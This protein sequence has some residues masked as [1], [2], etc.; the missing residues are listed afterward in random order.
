LPT[1]FFA[2]CGLGSPDE[3][4]VDRLGVLPAQG[5]IDVILPAQFDRGAAMAGQVA[6][7]RARLHLLERRLLEG[8]VRAGVPEQRCLRIQAGGNVRH[9]GPQLLGRVDILHALVVAMQ[10]EHD[11]AAVGEFQQPALQPALGEHR[12]RGAVEPS[13]AGLV[14]N[15]K[16]PVE[17]GPGPGRKPAHVLAIEMLRGADR[18]G[19]RHQRQRAFEP[20]LGLGL[21]QH[22]DQIMHRRHA[23]PLVGMQ[24]RLDID[25]RRRRLGAGQMVHDQL[26][27][28]A[29]GFASDG[30]DLGLHLVTF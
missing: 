18:V 16:I 11:S 2:S 1:K 12:R 15:R 28:H 5:G 14:G 9:F 25:A 7:F 30:L 24:A 10:V 29:R 21:F 23:G 13:H 19:M 26:I 6:I 3:K 22:R 20:A 4:P 17:I 8:P 27:G